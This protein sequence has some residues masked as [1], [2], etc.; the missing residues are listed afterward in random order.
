[1]LITRLPV[2]F[3]LP[4]LLHSYILGATTSAFSFQIFYHVHKHLVD[5]LYPLAEELGR[6]VT[7][8]RFPI[9]SPTDRLDAIDALNAIL[10]AKIRIRMEEEDRNVN[11][12]QVST[13]LQLLS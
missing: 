3:C 7:S 6:L 10:R 9:K 4:A 5:G 11:L 12:V 8:E 13:F 2:C 1:M